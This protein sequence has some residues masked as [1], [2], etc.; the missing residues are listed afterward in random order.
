MTPK[1]RFSFYIDFTFRRGWFLL[2]LGLDKTATNEQ[3]VAAIKSLQSKAEKVDS[4]E[5]SAITGAVNAAVS[6]KKITA[7][8]KEHF[9]ALGKSAGVESLNKTLELMK[10]ASKPTEVIDQSGT[11]QPETI[12]LKWENLT[13]EIAAKIKTENP[14]QYIALFKEYYGFEPALS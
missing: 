5:L 4:I 13:P 6:A 12:A 8:Q 9:I 1:R 7:D 11:E 2:A 3:A 10:V 14:K